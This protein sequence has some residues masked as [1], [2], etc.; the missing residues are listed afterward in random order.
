MAGKGRRLAAALVCASLV[1][2]PVA[3]ADNQMGYQLFTAEQTA[4]LPRGG[5][6]LGIDVGRGQVITDSNMTFELL[7]VQA[8]RPGT[9]AA[10]AGLVSG[11]QIIA[12][13]GRVFASVAAF[14]GYVGSLRPGRTISVDY[15]PSAGGPE[16]AQR[17]GITVGSVGG[18]APT[19]RTVE[20]ESH[21]LSNG[22]KLAIGAGAVALFG[23]Y[24]LGC[25]TRHDQ[26]Q[27]SDRPSR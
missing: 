16:Q 3:E 26:P 15:L 25:F 13:D 7:K 12:V 24:E 27:Q 10:R 4:R 23:C 19:P 1:A 18:G 9:A 20:A 2:S 14:A 5:G 22:Q 8:V 21:G 17:V 11:D 6:S